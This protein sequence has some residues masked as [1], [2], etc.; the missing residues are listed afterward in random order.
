[1]KP[2]I[3]TKSIDVFDYVCHRNDPPDAR[4]GSVVINLFKNIKHKV[5]MSGGIYGVCE[6]IF[7]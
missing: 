3:S 5:V 6:F 2:Y 4:G 7:R 1:M